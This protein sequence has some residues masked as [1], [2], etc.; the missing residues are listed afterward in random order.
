LNV[1][2]LRWADRNLTWG[3]PD[4][5]D[6][7]LVEVAP[8]ELAPV[9][10]DSPTQA[11]LR[12]HKRVK[13]TTEHRNGRLVVRL[14][15]PLWL[16]EESQVRRAIEILTSLGERL[17]EAYATVTQRSPMDGS[18]YRGTI[19][20]S[21]SLVVTQRATEALSLDRIRTARTAADQGAG[22]I[23]AVALVVYAIVGIARCLGH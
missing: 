7:F 21:K 9:L 22:V 17:R 10:L 16:E 15:V 18:P 23:G 6:A 20:D 11:M 8:R 14:S 19:E 13:L 5:Y 12:D 1:V 3:A 2:K 4:F